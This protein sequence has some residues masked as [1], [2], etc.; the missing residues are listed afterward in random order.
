MRDVNGKKVFFEGDLRSPA[1][2]S[3]S[4]Q[5]LEITQ[6]VDSAENHRTYQLQVLAQC[7]ANQCPQGR[8]HKLGPAKSDYF[9]PAKS[10][11]FYSGMW[12]S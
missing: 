11:Y 3:L 9:C 5:E 4:Q 12:A 6:P 1:P 7:Q 2:K 10:D 8:G